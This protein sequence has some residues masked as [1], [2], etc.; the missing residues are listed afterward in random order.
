MLRKFPEFFEPL[1]CVSEK[2]PQNSRKISRRMSLPKIEKFT[3]ELLQERR[4][5][6]FQGKWPNKKKNIRT[7]LA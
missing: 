3:D 2:I 7:R 5:K 1:F 6:F 4:V